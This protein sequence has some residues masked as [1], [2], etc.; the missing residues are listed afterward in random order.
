[1]AMEDNS[2]INEILEKAFR[3]AL[4]KEH[5]YVTLEHLTLVL[6]ENKEIQDYFLTMGVNTQSILEDI[7]VFLNGQDYLV[8]SGLTKPRKTQSLER[9]FN[10][11]FTQALFNGRAGI[12]PQD[13]LLSILSEKNSHACYYLALHGVTKETFLDTIAKNNKPAN[14][15]ARQSD[16]LLD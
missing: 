8:V 11:A 10:R 7:L 15:T 2:A 12:A 5:E 14:K 13:M 1:M 6:L 4:H 9:A 3:F 16:K